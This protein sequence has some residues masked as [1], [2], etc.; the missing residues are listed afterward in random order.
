MGLGHEKH[1]NFDPADGSECSMTFGCLDLLH[2]TRVERS[3]QDP[4]LLSFSFLTS[5]D[6]CVVNTAELYQV[7]TVAGTH[8]SPGSHGSKVESHSGS[9][10]S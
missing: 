6:I 5:W 9:L 7:A 2:T 1:Y 3:F 4:L 8:R 10:G